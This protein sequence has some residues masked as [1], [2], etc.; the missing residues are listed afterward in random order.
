M[1]SMIA[2]AI[3]SMACWI[4]CIALM[5]YSIVINY[6]LVYFFIGFAL[7]WLYPVILEFILNVYGCLTSSSLRRLKHGKEC[8]DMCKWKFPIIYSMD[9]NPALLGFEKLHGLDYKL[10]YYIYRKIEEE[11][12]IDSK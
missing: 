12:I 6:N 3:V 10:P 9:Y 5:M 7:F 8:E 4:G 2:Y 1:D 11:E